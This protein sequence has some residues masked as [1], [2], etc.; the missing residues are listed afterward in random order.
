MV[1]GLGLLSGIDE[2]SAYV[3]LLPGLVLGGIGGALTIPLSGVALAAA[4]VEKSGV[5]SGVFNAAREAGGALGIAIIGAVVG[6]GGRAGTEGFA[7]GYGRGL[8][9]AAVLAIVAAVVAGLTLGGPRET[10]SSV[11][12]VAGTA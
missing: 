11:A 7:A 10:R 6:S 1:C 4:P 9:V 2:Q 8:A 12:A 5:A 3:D